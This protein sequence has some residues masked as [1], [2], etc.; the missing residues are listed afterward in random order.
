MGS[1]Q[2]RQASLKLPTSLFELPASLFELSTSLFELRRDKTTGQDD[3]AGKGRK[4]GFDF[5]SPKE[6]GIK[7]WKLGGLNAGKP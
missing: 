6:K 5:F 7:A 4:G 3:P 2:R 1:P